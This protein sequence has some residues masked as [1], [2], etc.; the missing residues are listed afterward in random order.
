MITSSYESLR[1]SRWD[2]QYHIVFVL[3]GKIHK[4]SPSYTS[5]KCSRIWRILTTNLNSN[6]A[7]LWTTHNRQASGSTRI[8]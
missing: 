3:Y 5:V 1:Y 6:P 2:C 4:Y 7:A 8:L